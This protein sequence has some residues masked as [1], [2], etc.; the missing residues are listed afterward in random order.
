MTEKLLV[1]YLRRLTVRMIR[2]A[3][4]TVRYDY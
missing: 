2:E 3:D 4:Y 1:N